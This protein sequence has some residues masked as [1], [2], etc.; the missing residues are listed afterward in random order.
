MHRLALFQNSK[1]LNTVNSVNN[2]VKRVMQKCFKF[3]LIKTFCKLY[4]SHKNTD[5]SSIFHHH[6]QLF[7]SL[8]TFIGSLGCCDGR[9]CDI[10][11]IANN[12][13]LITEEKEGGDICPSAFIFLVTY[14][15]GL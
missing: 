12:P 3:D 2:L 14:L 11:I 4:Q 9:L 1:L 8:T 5:T 15:M 6:M 10:S 13:T 7:R